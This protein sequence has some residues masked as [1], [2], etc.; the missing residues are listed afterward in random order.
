MLCPVV[1]WQTVCVTFL[2]I[3]IWLGLCS[4]GPLGTGHLPLWVI[5]PI[6]SWVF[7]VLFLM[8][9]EHVHRR[10]SHSYWFSYF[11]GFLAFLPLFPGGTLGPEV[12]QPSHLQHHKHCNEGDLD[13]NK[14]AYPDGET[15]ILKLL[16]RWLTMDFHFFMVD[17]KAGVIPIPTQIGRFIVIGLEGYF[18][19][20]GIQA[21]WGWHILY[22]WIIPGRLEFF[23][24]A[25]FFDYLP[26]SHLSGE[27]RFVSS[28][29]VNMPRWFWCPG[30]DAHCIH[31][32]WPS[33]PW[34]NLETAYQIKKK[35]YESKGGKYRT[36]SGYIFAHATTDTMQ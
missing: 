9:H 25:L 18:I 23:M 24:I 2:F 22:H 27:N 3:G 15:S 5:L 33:I 31:H 6:N 30:L 19:Y 14:H 12:L 29:Y 26:H 28:V 20:R 8:G 17:A 11:I 32:V 35:E 7:F 36:F 1:A 21:G 4:L 10:I 13:P 34:Y 16:P